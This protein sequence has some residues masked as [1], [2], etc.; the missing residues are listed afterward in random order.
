MLN[1]GARNDLFKTFQR[2]IKFFQELVTI[3]P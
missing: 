1:T 2:N 3:K